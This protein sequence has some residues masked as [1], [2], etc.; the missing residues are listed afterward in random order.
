MSIHIDCL[1][2]SGSYS[3]DNTQKLPAEYQ[4]A[5]KFEQDPQAS[6]QR[7]KLL[8]TDTQ[9]VVIATVQLLDSHATLR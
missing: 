6:L 7:L 5:A 3:A 1:H 9:Q 8:T 2:Q 4:R